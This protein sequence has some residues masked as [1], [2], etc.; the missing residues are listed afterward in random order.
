L[1]LL[2]EVWLLVRLNLMLGDVPR[3]RQNAGNRAE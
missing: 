1:V 3:R 2:L